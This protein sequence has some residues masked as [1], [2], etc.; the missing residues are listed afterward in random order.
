[1]HSAFWDE[2]FSFSGA[3]ARASL[4]NTVKFIRHGAISKWSGLFLSYLGVNTP[5]FTRGLCV[6]VCVCVW[7]G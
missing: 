1:M 4:N 3:A 7:G 6:G 2:E 5:L